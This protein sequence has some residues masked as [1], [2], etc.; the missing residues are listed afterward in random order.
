MTTTST[1]FAASPATLQSVSDEVERVF[2]V[3]LVQVDDE[4]RGAK[5]DGARVFVREGHPYEAD[6][7]M[8]FPRYSIEVRFLR[9]H[10]VRP[11]AED[12]AAARLFAA[13]RVKGRYPLLLAEDLQQRIDSFEPPSEATL[14][15][16]P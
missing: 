13:L 15:A 1:V 11:G 12:E 7:E 16:P 10:P 6:C 4:W 2:G 9:G 5:I 14:F 3:P 8:D